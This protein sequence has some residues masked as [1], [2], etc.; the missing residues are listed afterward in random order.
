MAATIL[1]SPSCLPNDICNSAQC[2]LCS[3]LP[4]PAIICGDSAP[5]WIRRAGCK[6]SS[7]LCLRISMDDRE[8]H[9]CANLSFY[10]HLVSKQ[11]CVLYDKQVT[12]C[13]LVIEIM[14]YERV[15]WIKSSCCCGIMPLF[16]FGWVWEELS[17]TR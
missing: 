15:V 1:R 11:V 12:D 17:R 13:A 7:N 16:R 5:A 10:T 2:R 14:T 4:R 9:S 3:S 6:D 8:G